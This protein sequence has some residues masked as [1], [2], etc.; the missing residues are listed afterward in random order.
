MRVSS[1]HAIARQVERD[2][3]V[4]VL[5][6]TKAAAPRKSVTLLVMVYARVDATVLKLP[7]FMR[8]SHCTL[9]VLDVA[10]GVADESHHL[11]L[12][13]RFASV[14]VVGVVASAPVVARNS[15]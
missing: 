10:I 11:R 15:P 7:R 1:R 4:N 2:E 3:T 6:S 8:N 9:I 5:R 14:V 12:P 13:R